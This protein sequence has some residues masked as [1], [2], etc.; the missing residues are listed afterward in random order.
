[1]DQIVATDVRLEPVA[2]LADEL[3]DQDLPTVPSG[4]IPRYVFGPQVGD[5]DVHPPHDT[6]PHQLVTD[7]YAYAVS[8][9]AC[10]IMLI[11]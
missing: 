3:P 8:R 11:A 4:G 6:V 2:R 10:S 7:G 5:E 9:C 1:M